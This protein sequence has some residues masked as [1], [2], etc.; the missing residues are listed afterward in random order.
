[1]K[2]HCLLAGIAALGLALSACNND[3][4]LD[5]GTSLTDQADRLSM[6]A[7]DFTV[8]TRSV[9]ADSVLLRSSYCY[10][11][12]VRDPE[13]RAYVTS[14]FMTQFN[15]LET[16]T[17]PDE[18]KVLSRYGG[19]AA[20][21]SC[22]IELYLGQPNAVTDT[23]AAVKIRTAEL[24]RPME[25]NRRYYSNFDPVAQGLVSA[26]GFHV[27][28]MFSYNDPTVNTS[29]ISESGFKTVIYVKMNQPYTA[30][31]GQTY[32]N[33]GTY[34]MQQYYRH[35]EYFKNSY[36][37]IHNVCPGFYFSVTDGEGFYSEIPE[38]CLRL[39]YQVQVKA[40]SVS[41]YGTALAGTEEVL[42]T[43]H[44]SNERDALQQLV[45]DRS[46]TYIKAPAGVYTEVELPVDDIFAGHEGDSV[47][48]AEI[49]FQR[50]NHLYTD[51]AFY[52]PSYMMMVPKD[53]L[54]T[55][56]EHSKLPDNK[57]TYCAAHQA[58]TNQYV[59]SNISTLVTRLAAI[60]REGL[61]TDA[62]WLTR[63]PDWNKVLLVPVQAV[64]TTTSGTTTISA[65]EHCVGLAGTKLVGGSASAD[66][67]VKISVT[68]G[69]FNP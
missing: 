59:F 30:P 64:T 19:M 61:K 65:Y 56:F 41:T 60:K 13:T 36:T 4:T 67:P 43:T 63:H 38:M 29:D 17:M 16:F 48:Q 33:Y 32:N 21:D 62:A 69:K 51:K 27:D 34:V 3:E 35:P 45:D 7:A 14:E 54:T 66:G 15:L 6:S 52:V 31:D 5:I 28:R 68:Y 1:M 37:F 49:S 57:L 18:D 50:L 10:L 22:Q 20:A 8:S 39:Y 26:D 2:K 9:L 23:S 47:M 11:G 25:E 46:C 44:I 24:V 42:Q 53:S 40:D 58:K 12:R 55:F